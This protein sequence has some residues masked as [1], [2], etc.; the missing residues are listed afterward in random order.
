MPVDDDTRSRPPPA[1]PQGRHVGPALRRGN[2][3][4]R[5][6]RLD[7]PD[8]RRQKSVN[9]KLRRFRVGQCL[10][11]MDL[12]AGVCDHLVLCRVQLHPEA[13][14]N[15]Q[16]PLLR[17]VVRARWRWFQSP[18]LRRG[19]RAGRPR[20][21]DGAAGAGRRGATEHRHRQAGRRWLYRDRRR[22]NGPRLL[23]RGGIGVVTLVGVDAGGSHGRH[24]GREQAWR[25][26]PVLAV[27][28]VA[29]A[30]PLRRRRR[31]PCRQRGRRCG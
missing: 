27:G 5:L 20:W 3:E 9:R 22:R 10:H 2:D 1:L 21:T 15:N 23:R 8:Q 14:S 16:H 13:A 11:D 7:V 29:V 31:A 4:V 26:L 12:E 18:P 30:V 28:A 6:E 25:R 24:G 19:R 17:A